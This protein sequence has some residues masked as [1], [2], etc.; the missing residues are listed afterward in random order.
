MQATVR[1][2]IVIGAISFSGA[3]GGIALGNFAA[4]EQRLSGAEELAEYHRALSELEERPAAFAYPEPGPAVV[5]RK[6]PIAYHCEGCDA[7]L[8]PEIEI[9]DVADYEPLPPYRVYDPE[10]GVRPMPPLGVVPANPTPRVASTAA[11]ELPISTA[12]LMPE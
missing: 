7:Q 12:P 8:Y 11:S 4:E 3:A 5:R 2:L 1:R 6:G 10:G 9:G